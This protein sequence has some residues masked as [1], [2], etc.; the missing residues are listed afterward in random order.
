MLTA[1]WNVSGMVLGIAKTTPQ[2]CQYVLESTWQ[3]CLIATGSTSK[4][5]V[6]RMIVNLK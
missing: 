5:A 6:D 1:L 2:G 4:I 3:Q